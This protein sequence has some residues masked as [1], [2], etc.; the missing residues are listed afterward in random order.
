MVEQSADEVVVEDLLDE[1]RTRSHLEDFGEL[2]PL[3]ALRSLVDAINAESFLRPTAR[4][5]RRREIV[6]DLIT[7][8]QMEDAFRRHPEI[9]DQPVTAPLVIIGLQRTGTSKLFRAIASDPRWVV[10][11]TWQGLHP[12]PIGAPGS[13]ED[14]RERVALAQQW[15]DLQTELG[16]QP[17]HRVDPDAPEMEFLLLTK[18]WMFPTPTLVV[19]THQRWCEQADYVDIYRYFRRQLQFL[20][21][22]NDD[23]PGARWLLK[24]PYHLA[25]L[26]ALATV[27][28]DT[29]FVMNHRHP[30]TS[31]ASMMRI[32]EL[33][34]TGVA[35]RDARAAAHEWFHILTFE[36]D[37]C[38]E[39]RDSREA[40]P[41]LDVAYRDVERDAA[42]VTRTIYEWVG[43]P[44][45]ESAEVA[46]RAWED[47][48]PRH[49]DGV[50]TYDLSDYSLG[51]A[52]V[53]MAFSRY[54]ERFADWL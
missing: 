48:N 3:P 18:T 16:L 9:A 41:V 2:D 21:W 49:R 54:L 50:F 20:Q 34:Q 43:L 47:E 25:N 44:F 32:V 4:A 46:I 45:E 19:P 39:Y 13:E 24:Y 14:R 53:E 42:G 38:L 33:M 11:R 26:H 17:A 36:I 12:I 5:H 51:N 7:R 35:D 29:S 1:A 22:Q 30:G 27:F 8:L 15:V 31:V 28:P 37:R 52:D 10:L 23:P 6:T 40:I